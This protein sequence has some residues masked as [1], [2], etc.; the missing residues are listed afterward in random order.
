MLLNAHKCIASSG[1]LALFE[2]AVPCRQVL[3]VVCGNMA[4][5]TS[6][7][8]ASATIQ[9]TFTFNEHFFPASL[10]FIQGMP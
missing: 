8:D 9:V 4:A 5:V 6:S 1:S 10:A 7:V 3:A 2:K